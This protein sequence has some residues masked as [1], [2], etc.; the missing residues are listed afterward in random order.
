MTVR[1]Q[2]ICLLVIIESLGRGGG[3]ATGRRWQAL[4]LERNFRRE[5]RAHYLAT[6]Q[7]WQI[8][9]SGFAKID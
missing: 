9:R 8:M 4:E 7:G 6:K 2:G 3:A 5:T 1:F